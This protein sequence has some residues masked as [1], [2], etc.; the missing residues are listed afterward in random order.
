MQAQKTSKGGGLFGMFQ[1]DT[2][3]ADEAGAP[4]PSE[5]QVDRAVTKRGMGAPKRRKSDVS[6]LQ[7]QAKQVSASTG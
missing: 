4:P 5:G 7:G 1:Q 3:Y 2:V 6:Q